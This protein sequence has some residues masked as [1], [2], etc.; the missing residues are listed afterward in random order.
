MLIPKSS[1]PRFPLLK[2]ILL[3]ITPFRFHFYL[4]CLL[5]VLVACLS[6]A[7]PWL[8][9]VAV[10]EHI[11]RNDFE[12]L[13][14]IILILLVLLVLESVFRYYF[15]YL[16]SWLGQS[17]ITSLR[18]KVFHHI[19]NLRPIGVS[20]T[21]TINDI[22]A[23]NNIFAEGL[24]TIV[25]DMITLFAVMGFMFYINWQ[26]TLICRIPIPFLIIITYIF[27]EKVKAASEVVRTQVAKL[28]SFVQEHIT[29]INVLQIFN[30]EEREYE[31]FRAIND[32][33]KRAHIRTIWYYSIFFPIVELLSAV[34]IGLLV[35]WGAYQV[36]DAHIELGA[37]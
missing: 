4:S 31:K 23:I 26:L 3:L 21:R 17:I 34:S 2:R 12:G 18:V 5:A 1:K 25:S 32:Q 27:K 13:A 16:T 7:R 33:H 22:E 37:G 19:I 36:I 6:P 8:I 28:N 30:A 10:D 35:W 9:Q 20:I 24:V 29:G 14:N 15:I 11:L